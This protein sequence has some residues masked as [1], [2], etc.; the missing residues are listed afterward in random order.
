MSKH[1]YTITVEPVDQFSA[2]AKR[3]SFRATSHDDILAI[4]EKIGDDEKRLRL[5][6]GVKLFGGVMLEDRDNPL[7]K[8]YAPHFGEFMKKLKKT[9]GKGS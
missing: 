4:A 3:L 1:A 5:L 8:E 7:F 9:M 6:L 2:G